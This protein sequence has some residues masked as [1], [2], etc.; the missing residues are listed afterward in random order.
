[1]AVCGRAIT[2]CTLG[3]HPSRLPLIRTKY[4]FCP[5]YVCKQL[6]IALLFREGV[7]A[8]VCCFV[9]YLCWHGKMMMRD[10]YY[11]QMMEST[12]FTPMS[13]WVDEERMQSL[14]TSSQHHCSEEDVDDTK[15]N[16]QSRNEADDLLFSSSLSLTPLVF[17]TKVNEGLMMINDWWWMTMI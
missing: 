17:V 13:G 12:W 1:M 16:T 10:D 15:R 11:I 3:S 2:S 4:G 14:L 9:V 6:T 5:C 7:F 8:C